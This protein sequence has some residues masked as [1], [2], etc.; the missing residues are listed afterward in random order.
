MNL[1]SDIWGAKDPEPLIEYDCY[2]GCETM[3]FEIQWRGKTYYNSA[4]HW[5]SLIIEIEKWVVEHTDPDNPDDMFGLCDAWDCTVLD[6]ESVMDGQA[7]MVIPTTLH[8][9][10]V[11]ARAFNRCKEAAELLAEEMVFVSEMSELGQDIFLTSVFGKACIP[12]LSV[13]KNKTWPDIRV[14]YDLVASV[15]TTLLTRKR[16]RDG[17]HLHEHQ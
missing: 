14:D 13:L 15:W 10:G 7:E 1:I 17:G 2:A 16:A 11:G 12:V 3:P 6:I 9:M 4:P 8:S 5:K